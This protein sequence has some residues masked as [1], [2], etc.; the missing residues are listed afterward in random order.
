MKKYKRFSEIFYLI[1]L[2]LTI[3]FYLLLYG[4]SG[5]EFRPEPE[6]V[7]WMTFIV[8]AIISMIAYLTGRRFSGVAATLIKIIFGLTLVCM[9]YGGLK[10]LGYMLNFKFGSDIGVL[11]QLAFYIIPVVFV[12]SIFNVGYWLIKGHETPEAVNENRKT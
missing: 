11:I 4:A 1:I 7:M 2:L 3:P 5:H 8:A 9:L 12:G 10:V 6:D